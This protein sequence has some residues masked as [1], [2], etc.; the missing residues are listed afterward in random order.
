MGRKERA[1]KGHENRDLFFSLEG[2]QLPVYL[3]EMPKPDGPR[4]VRTMGLTQINAIDRN[5]L[6]GKDNKATSYPAS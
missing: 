2:Q 6:N 4:P 3:H 5:S 1:K